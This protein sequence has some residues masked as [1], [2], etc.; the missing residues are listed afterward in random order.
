MKQVIALLSI[1][2]FVAVGAFA[3]VNEPVGKYH[4]QP[5]KIE[6]RN[7]ATATPPPRADESISPAE[8]SGRHIFWMMIRQYMP[9]ERRSGIMKTAGSVHPAIIKQIKGTV[10]IPVFLRTALQG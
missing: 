7:N 1:V 3:E 8:F 5:E 9:M 10:C 2:L 4:R 6:P